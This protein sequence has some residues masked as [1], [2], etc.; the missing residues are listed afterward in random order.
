[1]RDASVFT[2]AT[3]ADVDDH[4]TK[5][6]MSSPVPSL[7]IEVA[8]YGTF[9]PTMWS[10]DAGLTTIRLMLPRPGGGPGGGGTVGPFET[11]RAT[12][13][14]RSADVPPPGVC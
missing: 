11:T 4:T 3:A 1:M 10:V 7:L 8:L 13:L 14:P 2:V 6:V 9:S 12:R 5:A